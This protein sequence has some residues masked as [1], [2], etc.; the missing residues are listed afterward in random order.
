MSVRIIRWLTAVY[1][2][3]FLIAV[4]WPGFLL[5]NR[6]TPIIIGLPFNLFCIALFIVIGMAVLFLL[7]RS[8]QRRADEER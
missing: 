8:E 5:F 1:M 6:V 3:A 2:F 4:I 7:Y